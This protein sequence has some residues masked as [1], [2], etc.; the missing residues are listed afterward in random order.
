MGQKQ[1]NFDKNNTS[2]ER[3]VQVIEIT[4]KVSKI[5]MD[6]LWNHSVA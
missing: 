4:P 6:S 3:I 1:T 5:P 2:K